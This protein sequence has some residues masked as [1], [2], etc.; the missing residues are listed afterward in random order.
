MTARSA[1]RRVDGAA[2][3]RARR[4][5]G[6]APPCGEKVTATS[7]SPPGGSSP[8]AGDTTN[9]ARFVPPAPGATTD[10]SA[11]DAR[12]VNGARVGFRIV[13]LV[14]DAAPKTQ[15]PQSTTGIFSSPVS[16]PFSF[17]SFPDAGHPGGGFA[18]TSGRSGGHHRG[19]GRNAELVFELFD[20]LV[21]LENSHALDR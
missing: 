20:E 2:R 1:W 13:T 21:Q 16:S 19:R 4:A 15:S 11:K 3:V 9:G 6:A 18:T 12:Q 5:P 8:P 10:F 7:A 17:S 14:E